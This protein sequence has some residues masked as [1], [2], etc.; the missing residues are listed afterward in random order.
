MDHFVVFPVN[1]DG[2]FL[3]PKL[4][5]GALEDA[6]QPPFNFSDLFIYSHGWW[7]NGNNA[8]AEYGQYTIEFTKTF[9]SARGYKPAERFI[10]N[11]DPL[12]I[13]AE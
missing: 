4:V 3:N 2:I 8:M 9:L 13:D 10:R 5:G 6:M 12:A 1:E 11:W 7:T